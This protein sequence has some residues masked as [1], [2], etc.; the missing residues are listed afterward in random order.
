MDRDYFT[1]AGMPFPWSSAQNCTS[2]Q[3]NFFDPNSQ[4]DSSSLTSMVP[5]STSDAFIL[6]ELIGKLGGGGGAAFPPATHTNNS[7]PPV[8]PLP[9]LSSDPGFA[10]RAAK[11]S[12]F[13][14]RSIN[15]RAS[16]SGGGDHQQGPR[17]GNPPISNEK[18]P[19]VSS[20]PS[21]RSQVE[22]GSALLSDKKL[23]SRLSG[24]GADSNEESSVSEQ[25]VETGSKNSNE[26]NSRK[27][28]VVSRGK[29][30]EEK[31]SLVGG[32]RK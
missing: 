29:T 9:S 14:S 4:F 18:L 17:S 2:D 24:S 21:L 30:K 8:P 10:E 22:T 27:R 15:G 5:S 26:L 7:P 11:F 19:R 6:R 13:G 31:S 32:V 3:S 16:P 23:P 1:N 28:K 20:S 25:I 12:C